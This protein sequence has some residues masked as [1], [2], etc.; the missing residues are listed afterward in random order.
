MISN[1]WLFQSMA[2]MLLQILYMT[3]PAALQE[4]NATHR[5]KKTDTVIAW[6]GMSDG[7]IYCVLQSLLCLFLLKAALL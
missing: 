7:S 2:K 5:V 3:F 6:C 4:A 1:G